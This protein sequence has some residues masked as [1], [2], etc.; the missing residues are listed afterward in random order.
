MSFCILPWV[1]LQLNPD[2]EVIPCCRNADDTSFGATRES[3]L[4][5]IWN[6][7]AVRKMRLEMLAGKVPSACADCV[8]R[9]SWGE[10]S[11]RHEMNERFAAFRPRVEETLPDGT[12]PAGGPV[13]LGLRLSNLCNFKCRSCS[14]QWSSGIA[15]ERGDV[16]PTRAFELDGDAVKWL[17]PALGSLEQIYFAGGEPLLHDDHY[18]VLE[19]LLKA[20]RKDVEL[21][22]NTNLSKLSHKGWSATELWS[23]FRR[24][25]IMASLDAVGER[26]ETLRKG[27][28]WSEIESCFAE[29]RRSVPH[30][31]FVVFPTVSAINAFHL[32]EAILRWA[33]LGMINESKDLR[34]NLVTIPSHLSLR[35]LDEATRAELRAEYRTFLADRARAL[36]AG[37]HAAT[38]AALG[39]VLEALGEPFDPAARLAFRKATFEFDRLREERLVSRFPELAGVLYGEKP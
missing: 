7:E 20:G 1:H 9:E 34:V 22:Y 12:L 13:Y 26:A 4:P 25:T 8:R 3:S 19:F 17:E 28:R 15:Q 39:K 27:T 24:V 18:R 11:L 30:A 33:E 29:L 37:A 36:P 32:P 31:H 35:A 16:R 21:L 5:E 23:R 2:G 10:R 38:T 6:G 14:A